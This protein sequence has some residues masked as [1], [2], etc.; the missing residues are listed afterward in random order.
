MLTSA[1]WP[2]LARNLGVANA[3]G[4][5]IAFLDDDDWW[6]E[7]DYLARSLVILKNETDFVQAKPQAVSRHLR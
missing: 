4:Q 5:F 3:Q 2:V 7:K 6:L 1:W